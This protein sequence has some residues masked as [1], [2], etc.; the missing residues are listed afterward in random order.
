MFY[1]LDWPV[2]SRHTCNVLAFE[3]KSQR[4]Q[5]C[6]RNISTPCSRQDAFGQLRR[7]KL[8]NENGSSRLFLYCPECHSF[9]G[10]AGGCL[11]DL[12]D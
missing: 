9:A 11:C 10:T 5:W 3:K 8:P 7:N 4:D 12:I 1:A 6:Y 2:S